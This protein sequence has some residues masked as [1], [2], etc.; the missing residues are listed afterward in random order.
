MEKKSEFYTKHE[1]QL[2]QLLVK[3]RE[4]LLQ[5]NIPFWQERILDEKYPGYLNCFDCRGNLEDTRKP[6]WF[7]GR[8]MYLFAALY[9][10]IEPREEWRGIAKG[11]RDFMKGSFYLGDGRFARMMSR[12]GRV[13]EGAASIFTDHFAVKG[14]YEYICTGKEQPGEQD[15]AFARLLSER[16][17]ENVKKPAVL[18]AEGIGPGWQKHAVNFMTLLVALESRSVFGNQYDD[19]LHDCVKKSLYAFAND[20]YKAPFE[21]IGADGKPKL[22]GEGRLIDAGHTMESLWFSMRAGKECGCEAY[23]KRA[24]TVLDWVIA[25][26]YDEEHGGFYQHVD[27][28]ETVPQQRFLINDYAGIPAA[29]D[30]KIW[31]VQAEG[32]N[33]LAMS[34]LYNENER[35]FTYFLKLYDYVQ[36]YFRDRE[37]GEW[38]SILKRD[39]AVRSDKK[40][41]ELKGPYHVP[42]CLMQLTILLEA[43]LSRTQ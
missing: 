8:T 42:R 41:F 25:R 15:V 4:E 6:G 20:E 10:R 7:V 18:Q 17:F 5:E 31:W 1:K 11:G 28:D 27:V 9:N 12:D 43:Y 29:W 40:G 26:C 14:L 16:L 23:I 2:R 13:L 22:E 33:A 35:H 37:F 32:L 38:Y 30:D 34:A 3:I 24:E 39:G 19:I 21:Y 36:N